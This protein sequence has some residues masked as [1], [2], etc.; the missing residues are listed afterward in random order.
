MEYMLQNFIILNGCPNK[1]HTLS[2]P[3]IK[4][5]NKSNLTPNPTYNNVLN[6]KDVIK[7]GFTKTSNQ[8]VIILLTVCN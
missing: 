3:F 2:S 5:L 1:T 7:D 8:L 6:L 4:Y